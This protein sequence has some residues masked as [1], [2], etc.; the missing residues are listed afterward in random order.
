MTQ[1]P[2]FHFKNVRDVKMKLAYKCYRLFLQKV[3]LIDDG[4]ICLW[5]HE[6]GINS[7]H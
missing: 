6:K 1:F 2:D 3:A 5:S 7:L 4:S